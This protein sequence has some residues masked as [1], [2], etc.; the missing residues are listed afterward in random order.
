VLV[1]A[2]VALDMNRVIE[3]LDELEP[4]R[5]F[6]GIVRDVVV[7]LERWC[8]GGGDPRALG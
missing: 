8:G 6:A 2:Y 1:H 4:V 7:E 3:A 5:R